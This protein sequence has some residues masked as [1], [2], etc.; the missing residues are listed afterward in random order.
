MTISTTTTLRRA[1]AA[2]AGTTLVLVGAAVS[3]APAQSTPALT[4]KAAAMTQTPELTGIRTGRHT[5]FDR[6][7]LDISGHTPQ[8]LARQWTD[9]L[10]AD[11]S[12]EIEWLTGER[13][14]SVTISPAAAHREDGT[15]SY[16]GPRKFRTRDL[17]N[18]M[19]V[20]ITGDF[21]ATLSVGLGTRTQAWVRAFTLTSPTRVVIDVGH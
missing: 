14:L 2:L 20:A 6:V 8:I 10:I 5:G 9:E 7:V 4:A 15:A 3:A 21:E 16:T 19:A 17:T 11:P 1:L 13:F 12:G 18:V